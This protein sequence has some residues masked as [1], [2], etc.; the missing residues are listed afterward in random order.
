M[1]AQHTG[2]ERSSIYT[3]ENVEGDDRLLVA[4]AKSGYESAFG[5]LYER[6]RSKIYRTAFRILRNQQDAEDAV[7]KCFQRVFTNLTRFR[8]DST[9]STWVT[10][11]AINEA[12]MLLRQRRPNRALT[13]REGADADLHSLDLP[14]GG[15]TPEQ[16]LAQ[17]ELRSALISAI[18]KAAAQLADRGCS[19]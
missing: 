10:R 5:A 6:H 13:E 17:T 15:P 4:E 12:L 11:I 7:Q 9:F 1:N 3:A 16:S 2:L 14:D 19:P 8:E 18:S